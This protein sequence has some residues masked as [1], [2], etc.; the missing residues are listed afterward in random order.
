MMSALALGVVESASDVSM[1]HTS[2]SSRMPET[3]DTLSSAAQ[4]GTQRT[5]VGA[6]RAAVGGST[7]TGAGV[8]ALFGGKKGAL[9]GA[10][11]GGGASTLWEAKH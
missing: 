10:A 1:T 4:C 11:T 7:A 5:P 9:I 6:P 8:G 2:H 3:R